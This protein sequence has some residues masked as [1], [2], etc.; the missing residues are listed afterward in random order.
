MSSTMRTEELVLNTDRPRIT[1]PFYKALTRKISGINKRMLNA[2]IQ[3]TKLEKLEKEALRGSTTE[4]PEQKPM[5][6][7]VMK[8]DLFTMILKSE[9]KISTNTLILKLPKMPF[10]KHKDYNQD[11]N[12]VIDHFLN[13]SERLNSTQASDLNEITKKFRL[14]AKKQSSRKRNST[15]YVK[16]RYQRAYEVF[17]MTHG[18]LKC[19]KEPNVTA[20]YINDKE[21]YRKY[22]YKPHTIDIKSKNKPAS[23]IL[24]DQSVERLNTSAKQNENERSSFFKTKY[25]TLFTRESNRGS[26]SKIPCL[27]LNLLVL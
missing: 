25:S 13:T 19:A 12:F 23:K 11:G 8:P 22:L 20:G 7:A 17:D 10:G 2:E 9:H 14:Y 27:N 3:P 5:K 15:G 21:K 26:S 18:E 16:T 4:R 6:K 1:Q 24:Q